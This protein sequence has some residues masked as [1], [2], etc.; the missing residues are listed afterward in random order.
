MNGIRGLELMSRRLSRVV[1][2]VLTAA[3]VKLEAIMVVHIE[4]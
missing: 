2:H 1:F 3:G 4:Q